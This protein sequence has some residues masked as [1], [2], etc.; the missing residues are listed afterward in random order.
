MET[1]YRGVNNIEAVLFPDQYQPA[2]HDVLLGMDFLGAIHF[3]MY[4]GHFI[5]S[6]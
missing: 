4:G 5:I 6:I 3:T 2:N 1:S